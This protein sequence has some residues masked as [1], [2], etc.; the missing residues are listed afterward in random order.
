MRGFSSKRILVVLITALALGFWAQ[1]GVTFTQAATE[2]P[3]V[4][5]V[6]PLK[7]E[8]PKD[9]KAI[10][11]KK[12]AIPPATEVEIQRRF[13]E[14]KS[15]VLDN[16]A[17]TI[18]W[19]LAVVAIVLTFFGIVVAILGLI[20]F[21]KFQSIEKEARESA[22]EAKQIVADAQKSGEAADQVATDA[23]KSAEDAKEL[24]GEMTG[25]R[26]ES[27][28]L[29]GE[30]AE[31]SAKAVEQERQ[32]T[33]KVRTGSQSY[34]VRMAVAKA[35]SL[36]RQGKLEEAIEKWRSIANVMQ[37]IDD[38]LVA[39]AWFFI[40]YLLDDQEDY[41]KAIHAYNRSIALNPN[42]VM[43]YNNRGLVKSARLG[44]YE[45]AI[46][47]YDAAI[48]LKEDYDLA[49]CNRGIVKDKL[50]QHEAAI[51]DFNKAVDLKK[52][53]AGTYYSRGI[54][55]VAMGFVD[56]AREDFTKA[57]DLAL[58]A[59]NKS[60]SNRAERELK[61]IDEKQDA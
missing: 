1:T 21:R 40:G 14:L 50:G 47:D 28:A 18:E 16:R 61:K 35:H 53:F 54:T 33:E 20:G 37:G 30:T 13:N 58:A 29:L 43:A 57:R 44:Q 31:N 52:D 46:K 12:P 49:Y 17:D 23:R 48:A 38:D 56:G 6:A 8:K 26:D 19:W 9:Q 5:K 25:Y 42:D 55:K 2:K 3:V 10:A 15:E 4:Q 41:E 27:K 7:L 39:R 24:V 45:D 36:H 60:L 32:D 22:K 11:L 59:G 51:V 34:A